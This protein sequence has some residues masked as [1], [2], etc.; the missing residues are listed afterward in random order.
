MEIG[1]LV[2]AFASQAHQFGT[3]ESSQGV[4]IKLDTRFTETKQLSIEVAEKT[5]AENALW[6]P[7]GI[8][9]ND[10]TWLYVQGNYDVVFVFAKKTLRRL[11]QSM[12]LTHHEIAT[13]QGFFLPLVLAE[14]HA[15]IV[16]YLVDKDAFWKKIL[17]RRDAP[18][19]REG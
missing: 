16:I 5:K 18:D 15:A 12:L 10:N 1:I 6:V 7:S 11:H 13:L 17:T 3:G 9:R 2:Q 4:E 19:V 8:Y 14:A